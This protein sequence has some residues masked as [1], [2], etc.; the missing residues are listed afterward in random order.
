MLL[1]VP[2]R[3]ASLVCLMLV[4][5]G[6]GRA[7]NLVSNGTFN[8]ASTAGWQK[9]GGTGGYVNE[10]GSAQGGAR[11]DWITIG[12][13]LWQT[14]NTVAGQRYLL[15]FATRG[16]NPGQSYRMATM[17]V[18]WGGQLIGSYTSPNNGIWTYPSFVVEASGATELRFST[19][20]NLQHP[21]LDDVVVVPLPATQPGIMLTS[22]EAGASYVM[23][24]T[25]PLTASVTA[26]SGRTIVRV[27]YFHSGTTSIVAS[28]VA[29]FSAVWTNVPPGTWRISARVMDS[30][31]ATTTAA[32]KQ[33]MVATRPTIYW[34]APAEGSVLSVGDDVP[35]SVVLTNNDRVITSLVL[36]AGSN[37]VARFDGA[38]TNGVYSGPWL[39]IPRG[40]FVLESTGYNSNGVAV[41]TALINVSV[42]PPAILDQWQTY[43]SST[44]FTFPGTD[45]A[46]TFTPG[47]DGELHHVEL[48]M[49]PAHFAQVFP[50]RVTVVETV[51][52]APTG[53]VLAESYVPNVEQTGDPKLA[54]FRTA[55]P[56]LRA[57]RLYAFIVSPTFQT[58]GLIIRTA[59][60]DNPYPRGAIWR[61]IGTGPWEQAERQ[62]NLYADMVFAT[63]MTP[64]VV[65]QVSLTSPGAGANFRAG[66]SIHLSATVF[67]AD[68]TNLLVEFF[69]GGIPVGAAAAPPY[70]TEWVGAFTGNFPMTAVVTDEIGLSSRSSVVWIDVEP[71]NTWPRVSVLDATIVEGSRTNLLRFPIT[72]SA[73]ATDDVAVQYATADG[74]AATG[75]D[76]EGGSGLVIFKAGTTN[77]TISV[78][79]YGDQLDEPHEFFLMN[80]LL[81]TGAN[82]G[83]AQA[84]GTVL[85]DEPGPGKLHHFGFTSIPSP[86]T[87]NRPFFVSVTALDVLNNVVTNFTGPVALSF[88][89]APT[90]L[91]TTLLNGV[92]HTTATTPAT[93]V[94]LGYAFTPST[95]LLV[96]GVRHYS[97]YYMSLWSDD[98]ELLFKHNLP[99]I[100]G[101]WTDSTLAAPVALKAGRTYRLGF[102]TGG[103]TW[104]G[105]AQPPTNFPHGNLGPS[106]Q[107]AGEGFPEGGAPPSW[108]LA[109]LRYHVDAPLATQI[110]PGTLTPFVNGRWSGTVQFDSVLAARSQLRAEDAL[111]HIGLSPAFDMNRAPAI[112]INSPAPGAVL[113]S[114]T[115]LTVTAD[116]SDP[117]GSIARVEF[118]LD[119]VL[120]GTDLSSPFVASSDVTP[121][122]HVIVARAFDNLGAS[123][124]ATTTVQVLAP[125]RSVA[126]VRFD[127]PSIPGGSRAIF[128]WKE[129]GFTFDSGDM[130]HTDSGL[131]GR[132][133]GEGGFL[134]PTLVTIA[135]EDGKPFSLISAELAEY[136]T[137]F[138]SPLDIT[139]QGW[140]GDGAVFTH[141]FTTDG[142]ID[143]IGTLNDFEL[144]DFPPEF[145][146]LVRAEMSSPFP[147][148]S[149]ENL[150]V[151]S[152]FSNAPQVQIVAPLNGEGFAPEGV[153]FETAVLL[154]TGSVTRVDFEVD[155][156]FVGSAFEPPYGLP[157]PFLPVGSHTVVATVF[158]NLGIEAA[159]DSVD[160]RVTARP[161]VTL[162]LPTN[163]TV[164]TVGEPITLQATAVDEGGAI[165]FVAFL[166]G[167]NVLGVATNAPF[168]MTW[169][170]FM[171]GPHALYAV[172]VDNLG[173][174]GTSTV[175]QVIGNI[176]PSVS[177]KSPTNQL[178]LQPGDTIRFSAE[179]TDPDGAVSFVDFYL[180]TNFVGRAFSPPYQ[181]DWTN[182]A[183][184][185]FCATAV[186]VDNHGAS[187]RDRMAGRVNRRPAVTILAPTT[188]SAFI[189]P[190]AIEISVQ[191]EDLDGTIR[192]IL[193]SAG[194]DF[195][196]RFDRVGQNPRP[197][198]ECEATTPGPS[199]A[200]PFLCIWSNVPAGIHTIR[201]AAVDNDGAS[202]VIA[203]ATVFGFN[204]PPVTAEWKAT[205]VVRW[206]PR[207]RFTQR[208]TISNPTGQ[209]LAPGE[210]M[211]YLDR[212][213][214]L[215]GVRVIG[216]TRVS[217]GIY[218]VPMSGIPALGVTSMDILYS[219][220]N[221]RRLPAP[222]IVPVL[223]GAN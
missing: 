14:V 196:A 102:F 136:S 163:G 116:A 216:G 101:S 68:S 2:A 11:G 77:A 152:D 151:A 189:A 113:Y 84:V 76:Y 49:F 44:V 178:V 209:T 156:A 15:S 62:P 26:G 112:T 85:D 124:S 155:G 10:L 56:V 198:L 89:A 168:W 160:F 159:S 194:V 103:L 83:R 12:G 144:F 41:S 86:Q 115:V 32:L 207:V 164:A 34:A 16:D 38:L 214:V 217:R 177:L 201:V 107:N 132:P 141:T 24:D 87:T 211:I 150:R 125:F 58:N 147:R 73:P 74:T 165:A 134:Q 142:I 92:P 46:Q 79:V 204:Y 148:F 200:I 53:T 213:S 210:L 180:A 120:I 179:A 42:L 137:F 212:Q 143:G 138:Q 205:N 203:E 195:T 54:Y 162:V 66:D 59:H 97:G 43:F 118:F 167:T 106:F 72:L 121:G 27:E 69:A 78:P 176:P 149:I 117:D 1:D 98:G 206:P 133:Q 119:G 55:P 111:G 184:G 191:A 7:Q 4:L 61:K 25:V 18:S 94:T 45:F 173:V 48:Y 126:T 193:V 171:S 169:S 65:P 188:Q 63:Y 50:V 3:A 93:A 158:D 30:G 145:S 67:D 221:R 197:V 6:N 75:T 161:F 81:V 222:L 146:F 57:G 19:A 202:S 135:R 99:A 190:D 23:G 33:I 218:R 36:R 91:G 13:S 223:H 172:A 52:G 128:Q 105:V 127:P 139:V 130:S 17:L 140:R 5:A 131:A 95:N 114:P 88:L 35:L 28:V 174:T 47:V 123:S 40:E 166:D 22:P 90:N 208:V 21:E 71:T 186:A 9:T 31:G 8:V 183:V 181:L 39:D 110:T 185:S 100:A 153:A 199:D 175:V 219:A 96:T 182:T 60:T 64:R 215:R 129:Q 109:D 108:P 37:V 220:P 20:Q 104:Y 192:T 82:L 187:S 154:V 122:G 29:P 70:E 51:G 80:L 170:N 157:W